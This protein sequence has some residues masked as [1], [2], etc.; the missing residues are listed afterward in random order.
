MRTSSSDKQKSNLDREFLGNMEGGQHTEYKGIIDAMLA[1]DNHVHCNEHR[2][3]DKKQ[4]STV[5]LQK[6][7]PC[8]N[9]CPSLFLEAFGGG[10][11]GHRRSKR[12]LMLTEVYGA[13]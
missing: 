12:V 2:E 5:N 11:V 9:G 6:W 13:S 7:G 4:K 1:P 3:N 8:G 10:E